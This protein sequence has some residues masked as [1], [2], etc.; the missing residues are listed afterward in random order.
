MFGSVHVVVVVV[1]GGGVAGV[2]C[3]GSV[4]RSCRVCCSLF[5]LSVGVM[6][7]FA[8]ARCALSGVRCSLSVARCVLCVVVCCS[9][10]FGVARCGSVF[11]G[12]VS[13]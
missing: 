12:V 2:S 10:L 5:P 13:C 9:V 6:L 4:V 1:G 11:V 3:P 8:G 7:W